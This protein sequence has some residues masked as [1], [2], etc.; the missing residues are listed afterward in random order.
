ML[1]FVI[2]AE[3][4]LKAKERDKKRKKLKQTKPPPHGD[5]S[6]QVLSHID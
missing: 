3:L 4:Q 2:D 1:Y 6:I 5:T